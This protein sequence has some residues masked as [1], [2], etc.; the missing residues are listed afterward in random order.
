MSIAGV[1]PACRSLDCV[2]IF[3]RDA[4]DGAAVLAVARGFD[5]EDPY[6]RVP[7]PPAP[8]LGAGF[9]FGVPPA[10]QREF[11]GDE[12]AARLYDVALER[13]AALGGQP[14]E[15]DFGPF[16]AAA[17]LL[18]S[19]PWVA[20]RLAAIRPFFERAAAAMDP[21][22]A[23]IIGGAAR[24]SAADAFEGMYRLET[25]RRAAEVQWRA[26]DVL[27]LPTTGT[28]YSHA[29]IAA[30]P[31]GLNT[32]LG[33]YTNFVNLLDLAAIAVPAGRRPNGLPFGLSL[34]APAFHDEA[35]CALAGAFASGRLA[36]AAERGAVRLAVVGAHLTGQPLNHELTARGGRLAWSGRTAPEY[37]L[38]ALAETTPPKPG[39]VRVGE[40]EGGAI[41]VEV[42]ELDAAD[43][44]ALVAAIPPPLAI[45]TL[46]L[47]GGG[48][49]K[50]FLCE[51]LAV[52]GA[53][54]IT[55]LGGWR[56]Y[57]AARW[58]R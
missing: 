17:D 3:A 40:G 28:I 7:A 1:V 11:F 54:D 15:I 8:L 23:R 37:R 2:S 39:L 26:M 18:Y 57:L 45:G 33:Y 44:G 41:E 46:R 10:A 27:A 31:I 25:L 50:G 43:F 58:R 32:N 42:W 24:L 49:V 47:E 52:E 36:A 53:E 48:A 19:G 22:V 14:V 4:E 13:L 34:I 56:A 5:A 20:E 30:D 38:Y 55:A 6:S 21:V 16:R 51:P 12:E 29:R 9:R 35:L